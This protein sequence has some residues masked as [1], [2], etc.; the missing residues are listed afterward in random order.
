MDNVPSPEFEKHGAVRHVTLVVSA[1]DTE[2]PSSVGS[3]DSSELTT[4][5]ASNECAV[6]LEAVVSVDCVREIVG[7]VLGSDTK[8]AALEQTLE[9]LVGREIESAEMYGQLFERLVSGVE[10]VLVGRVYEFCAGV[11]TRAAQHLGINRN[12]LHKKLCKYKLLSP[13]RQSDPLE[14]EPETI[15]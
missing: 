1:V 7:T 10:R 14:S 2:A 15:T 6:R 4:G 9:A 13:S 3:L 8:T 12:T 5:D 11:Q